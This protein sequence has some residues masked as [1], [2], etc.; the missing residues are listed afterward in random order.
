MDVK[1]R[2]RSKVLLFVSLMFFIGMVYS[3]AQI[4]MK[5][6]Q[7]KNPAHLLLR[8]RILTESGMVL[9]ETV[10]GKRVYPQKT[11]AGQLL[12]HMGR[13]AGLEGLEL[14]YE[15]TLS[16]GK[17]VVLSL[18][19]TFQ[20]V[21]ESILGQKV[22]EQDAE[23]G[24]IVALDV[25]TGKILAVANYPA[26]DPNPDRWETNSYQE[27]RPV[28]NSIDPV[29]SRNHAFL[30]E[31]EPGS[32]IKALTVAALIND[33][34]TDFNRWYPCPMKRKIGRDTIHDA[35]ARPNGVNNL[36]LY[37]ILRYSSN[38][39]MSHLVD[40]YPPQR[41]YSYFS[42]YGFGTRPD[43]GNV[44]AAKGKLKDWQSWGLIG[45][46][47]NSFGQ[48]LSTSTLQVA[49]GY[50]IIASGGKYIAPR[51]IAG[52]PIMPPLQ[53]L[54]PETTDKVKKILAY[55]VEEGIPKQASIPGYILG[56][57]TG[58]GQVVID[59]KYSEDI[60][61]SVFAGIFPLDHPRVSMVVMVYGARK[62][63]HGS[64]VAAPIFRDVAAEMVSKWGITPNQI[65]GDAKSG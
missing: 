43:L 2:S 36:D 38:V 15:A 39:G 44:F 53:V 22:V 56:G 14:S 61:S 62:L 10:G 6:P 18:D 46:V 16:A 31:Y 27:I 48:G 42:S 63:H 12:G 47:N 25:Q 11:L 20:T 7:P 23:H 3:Y 37:G 50:N 59:G 1:L 30:D 65:K 60:Y 8:G 51:L 9:A 28:W 13:D 41:L 5:M 17:D 54:R 35:V 52:E 32:V 64:Q 29:A 24:S 49:T 33:G 58:T 40:N 26:F 57:K 45:R 55:I 21:A 34:S 19:P 4:E